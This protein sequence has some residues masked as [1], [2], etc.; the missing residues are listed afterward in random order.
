MSR[1]ILVTG[2]AG[3]MGRVVCKGLL[4]RRNLSVVGMDRRDWP[5]VWHGDE[6]PTQGK[7]TTRPQGE[8]ETSPPSKESRFHYYKVDLRKRDAEDVFREEKPYAVIHLAFEDDQSVPRVR[9]HETNVLATQQVLGWC[10]RYGVKK[11]VTS[12]RAIAYGASPDNPGKI[13]EDMPLK[14]GA[15]YEELHDLVEYDYVCRSWMYEHKEVTTVLLRPVH[16][17]G[18]NIRAGMM[19]RYLNLARCP[20]LAGFDPMIQLVHE[21]D[22]GQAI[23]CALK[24]P[25]KG[26]YNVAGPGALPLSVLLRELHKKTLTLPH[27][28]LYAADSFLFRVGRSKL[29]PASFDFIRYNCLVDGSKIERELKYRPAFSLPETIAAIPQVG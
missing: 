27:P 22:M 11:V 8:E 17:V 2:A 19:F 25:A 9:R 21:D 6:T 5:A 23:G 24:A 4:A 20:V 26:I 3:G 10:S 13:T 15:R 28:L 12:S 1:K 14:M 7:R 18:P 16:V 29:P